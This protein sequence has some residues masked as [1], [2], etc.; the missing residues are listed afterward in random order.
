MPQ[1]LTIW[2][3]RNNPRMP[4]LESHVVQTEVHGYFRKAGNC[5]INPCRVEILDLDRVN[6]NPTNVNPD[7]DLFR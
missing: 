1:R 6:L 4:L 5:P 3:F 2:L 7:R